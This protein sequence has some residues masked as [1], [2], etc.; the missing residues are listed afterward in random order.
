MSACPGT[1]RAD[2]TLPA[3]FSEHMVLKK[4]ANVPIWGKA[5]PGEEV[6]VK[7]GDQV[8]TAKAGEDGKWK[9]LLDLSKSDPGPFTATVRGKNEISIPD[10]VVGEVWVASGQ[11]NMG[12]FLEDSIDGRK[13]VANSANPMLRQFRV[14]HNAAEE[15]TT[16]LAGKWEV[17]GPATSRQFTAVGYYFAKD[18]QKEINRPVGLIN[19]TW[20]GTPSEAWTSPEAIATMPEVQQSLEK[21]Q[22]YAKAF[23]EMTA[24]F[25]EAFKRWLNDTARAD[26]ATPDVAAFAGDKVS[27]DGWAPVTFPAK[28]TD[29]DSKPLYGAVWLRREFDLH[30]TDRGLWLDL[31]P[32]NGFEALY[33][34]GK[35]IKENTFET[36]Q[37]PWPVAPMLSRRT[38]SRR[39]A[40]SWRCASIHH[41]PSR[42]WSET[43]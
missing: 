19:T 36:L 35:L 7:V 23:S 9:A 32:I 34:N 3:I 18:I 41:P 37:N 29:A 42:P 4:A 11:S 30:K 40:T 28:I 1:I 16:E 22:A 6:T 26:K 14:T 39:A 24:T 2:V 8:A 12:F 27:E 5:S 38:R 21:Q 13:E 31:G 25:V 15:P 20:H 33:W 17:A 43:S 10:V